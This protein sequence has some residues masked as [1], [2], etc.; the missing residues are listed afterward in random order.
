MSEVNELGTQEIMQAVHRVLGDIRRDL[1]M[2]FQVQKDTLGVLRDIH[3]ELEY[4]R[5]ERRRMDRLDQMLV[6]LDRLQQRDMQIEQ[7]IDA[8]TKLTGSR[9][10]IDDKND[11]KSPTG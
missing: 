4:L 5:T 7:L 9:A 10:I 1:S 6:E 8:A 2:T 11:K 3:T